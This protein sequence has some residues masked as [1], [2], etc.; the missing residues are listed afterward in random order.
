VQVVAV[1][2][3][4]MIIKLFDKLMIENHINSIM[5]ISEPQINNQG[6][7]AR[8]YTTEHLTNI[9]FINIINNQLISFNKENDYLK[10]LSAEKREEF[11]KIVDAVSAINANDATN[12]ANVIIQLLTEVKNRAVSTFASTLT[13]VEEHI[14]VFVPEFESPKTLN[15]PELK[16]E[17]EEALAK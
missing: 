9:E 16:A 2:Y 3:S 4:I 1:V 12:I 11:F 8:S 14:V 15:N 5:I 17:I 10:S 7:Q 6:V 13:A